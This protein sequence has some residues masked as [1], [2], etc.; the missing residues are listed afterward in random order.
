MK[1]EVKNPEDYTEFDGDEPRQLG[2][3]R[4]VAR[5]RRVAARHRPGAAPRRQQPLRLPGRGRWA[6]SSSPP[7][8]TATPKQWDPADI[9][10]ILNRYHFQQRE[11]RHRRPASA[12]DR[13]TDDVKGTKRV[14]HRRRGAVRH[15]ARRHQDAVRAALPGRV[16]R[17]RRRRAHQGRHRRLRVERH[18]PARAD[19]GRRVP[20]P[21]A[22]RGSTA[23]ASAAAR[24]SSWSSTRPRRS[25]PATPRSS[26]SSTARPRAPT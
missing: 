4:R 21:A 23:P 7:T 14:A 10:R 16:A 12:A 18:G 19:R 13:S 5:V 6:S 8:R 2:A 24:G 1:I 20:R 22:R 3:R 15:R 17:D 11:P 26:C 9:G 25:W